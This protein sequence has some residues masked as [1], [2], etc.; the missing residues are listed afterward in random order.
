MTGSRRARYGEDEGVSDCERKREG[1]SFKV[2]GKKRKQ[3][4]V[5]GVDKGWCGVDNLATKTLLV[6]VTR[7]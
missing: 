7:I 6:Q 2:E 3:I 5:G 4:Q 1:C